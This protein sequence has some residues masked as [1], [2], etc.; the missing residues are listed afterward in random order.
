MNETLPDRLRSLAQELEEEVVNMRRRELQIQD[1][2]Q[3]QVE[4]YMDENAQL[5]SQ[6]DGWRMFSQLRRDVSEID[7][8]IEQVFKNRDLNESAHEL[9]AV[10]ARLKI[11]KERE[12]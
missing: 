2:A 3:N 5:R 6:I 1:I 10:Q 11:I 8:L 7:D 4:K 9:R 12:I